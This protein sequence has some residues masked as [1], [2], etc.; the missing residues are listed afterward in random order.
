MVIMNHDQSGLKI[1]CINSNNNHLQLTEGKV[2]LALNASEDV[3]PYSAKSSEIVY[4][5]II[6]DLGDDNFYQ[7]DLFVPISTMR[8]EKLK[9]LGI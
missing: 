3:N 5:R 1:I 6:D 8:D 2:Y 7:S 4:I 9:K